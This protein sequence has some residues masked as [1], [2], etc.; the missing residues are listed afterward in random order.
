MTQVFRASHT[1][2]SLWTSGRWQEA[3]NYYL[4]YSQY[5]T[6]AMID[7]RELHKKWEADVKAT[8]CLPPEFGGSRLA[9]PSTEQKI[10]IHLTEW[11]DLVGIIDCYEELVQELRGGRIHEYK[12]GVISSTTYAR[13]HQV[14]IYA[15]LLLMTGRHPKQA[16]LW[17]YNQHLKTTDLSIV[18]I[19]EQMIKD[20]MEWVEGAA[21]EMHS[22]MIQ[23]DLY[24]RLEVAKV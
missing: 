5:D 17:H 23:N 8:G 22:Y 12:S 19:D 6:Q 3:I 11:L 10:V 2:L 15:T 21:W 24:R 9:W 13:G 4:K 18:W 1:V 7:G 14:G 16:Y 20:A